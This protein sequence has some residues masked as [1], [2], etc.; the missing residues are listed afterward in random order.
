MEIEANLKSQ[1]E[2][3]SETK[4]NTK[5]KTNDEMASAVEDMSTNFGGRGGNLT[6][7]RYIRLKIKT[8]KIDDNEVL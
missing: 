8:L 3:L 4:Q 1:Q 5:P 7:M 6:D 2:P